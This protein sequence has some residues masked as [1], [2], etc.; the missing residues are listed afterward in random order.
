MFII[1]SRTYLVTRNTATN[2]VVEEKEVKKKCW[3][4][5]WKGPE[6]ENSNKTIR[7]GALSTIKAR[8]RKTEM[9]RLGSS[10]VRASFKGPSQVPLY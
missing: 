9:P 10:D 2:E 4:Y 1:S 7:W 5:T 3:M 8:Q 6:T